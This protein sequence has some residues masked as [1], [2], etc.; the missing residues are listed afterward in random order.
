MNEI[1]HVFLSNG[2]HFFGK[3]ISDDTT[4]TTFSDPRTPNLVQQKDG[5]AMTFMPLDVFNQDLKQV[6]INKNFIVY[7]VPVDK[8]IEN[9]YISSVTGIEIAGANTPTPRLRLSE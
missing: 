2:Q 9:H 6:S 3:V 4:T 7:T 1:K 5:I 8:E